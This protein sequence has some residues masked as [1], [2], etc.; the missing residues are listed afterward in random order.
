MM[1][2]L[3]LVL[4]MLLLSPLL[5]NAMFG[6]TRVNAQNLPVHNL[7]TGLDY[8]TIQDA[9]D[10]NETVAGNTIKVD[11]G[12]YYEPIRIFKSITLVGAGS[13]ATIIDGNG[14]GVLT[15]EDSDRAIIL[16]RANGI[17]I[18]NLTIRNGGLSYGPGGLDTCIDGAYGQSAIDVENCILQNA[19]SGMLF[20][21]GV[22]SITINN[23]TI[24]DIVVY[25]IDI[26]GG[27]IP[28]A[29]NVTISNNIISDAGESGI[30]LD[31]Y[32]SNCTIVNNTVTDSS[33]GIDLA[34]NDGNGV[35][36]WGNLV[37]GNVL[38]NNSYANMLIDAQY[39]LQSPYM[40][41]FRDNNLTNTLHYNL[42][43]WGPSSAAFVQDIDS[44][45]T[46]NNKPIYYLTN[47]NNAEIDP[48]N[49]QDA[50]YLALVNCTDV[51]V[52][53]FNLA[54]NDDGMVMAYSTNCTLTNMTLA[55]NRVYSIWKFANES[56]L[57]DYGGL[58]L[59][60][61]TGNTMMDST[62]Y[63]NTYGICLCDSTGNTF[64]HNAIINNDVPVV[65]DL[66]G[67]F[68]NVSTGTGIFC[69]NSWDNGVEGNYWSEYN[70]TGSDGIGNTPYVIDANNTDNH[71][72]MG[73]FSDFN[74]AEGVD[75]QVVSNS[76]VSDFE[77]NGTAI[78]FNVSGANGTTGF[79]NVCVPTTLLNG[80][81]TVF[82]NGTQ[83]QYSLLPSSNSTQT[84]L[85]FIYGHSTEQ[86]IIMPEFPEPLILAMFMLATLSA[87]AIHKKRH[88]RS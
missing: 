79:C 16:L 32:T 66:E 60:G 25:G 75:V 40:N 7:N 28:T 4:S 61:S 67:P 34:S 2:A 70:G 48:T 78:F 12:T 37:E 42:I 58:T 29:T 41:T 71:P 15:G 80:T 31:G 3:L 13:G 14:T 43:V 65:S 38:D 85:Y 57:W 87:I 86:V 56:F 47:V 74:V 62:V 19:G 24:S 77:F 8:A 6:Q 45:N 64:Y 1:L 26:G 11:A 46:A 53:N 51:T 9:L 22:S 39:L 81:L 50:G 76:T 83:V 88:R 73:T 30:N 49:C 10:A 82:V 55:D 23:N 54:S 17:S 69:R 21:Q 27:T 18:M 68:G 36:P 35:F 52:K 72:L 63:N 84:Y 33:F 44:S 59:Y 20:A 5:P